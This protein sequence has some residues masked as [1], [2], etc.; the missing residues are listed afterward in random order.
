MDQ[1][2]LVMLLWGEHRQS[3]RAYS[4]YWWAEAGHVA[5]SYC[6][7]WLWARRLLQPLLLCHQLTRVAQAEAELATAND[8]HGHAKPAMSATHHAV[9]KVATND[10][11]PQ[12]SCCVV[13]HAAGALCVY[14]GP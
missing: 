5:V 8:F 11:A 1:A 4:S 9:G 6:A 2:C 7:D 3:R 13:L 12:H 14:V 10:L